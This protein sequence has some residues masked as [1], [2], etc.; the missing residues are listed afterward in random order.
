MH[1]TFSFFLQILLF[2]KEILNKDFFQEL[3]YY[4]GLFETKPLYNRC[5]HLSD[6]YV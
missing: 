5:K 3:T 1:S 4:L 2:L 6:V